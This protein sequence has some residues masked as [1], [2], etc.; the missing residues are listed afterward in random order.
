MKTKL[1]LLLALAATSALHAEK[2]GFNGPRV[3]AS[4]SAAPSRSLPSSG[5]PSSS[6]VNAGQIIGIARAVLPQV[7]RA[8]NTPPPP[9]AARPA[10]KTAAS[11]TKSIAAPRASLPNKPRTSSRV[12]ARPATGLEGKNTAAIREGAHM[13]NGLRSLEEI[14]KAVPDAL[15]ESLGLKGGGFR[16]G[17]GFE[18]PFD[19]EGNVANGS[20]KPEPDFRAPSHS[21]ANRGNGLTDIRSGY[22]RSRHASPATRDDMTP[23]AGRIFESASRLTFGSGSQSTA[24]SAPTYTQDEA[25][26]DVVAEQRGYDQDGHAAAVVVIE[27]HNNNGTVA[28]TKELVYHVGADGKTTIDVIARDPQGH[29][30]AQ[31]TAR[32]CDRAPGDVAMGGPVNSSGP[33]VGDLAGLV[34]L[35]LLRQHANGEAPCGGVNYMTSGRLNRNQVNPTSRSG[36]SVGGPGPRVA[37]IDILQP[38][39]GGDFPIQ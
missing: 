38:A 8:F 30:V 13:A 3:P 12:P 9:P 2:P 32:S 36:G 20:R 31:G 11:T 29:I 17:A 22:S 14:R 6:R 7:V 23:A 4:A 10:P 39:G 1:S 26:G 27:S 35:D 5:G 21:G 16:H 33:S 19:S 24:D 37:P 15:N 34:P 18:M 25:N 28:G